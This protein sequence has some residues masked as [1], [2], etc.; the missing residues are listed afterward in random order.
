MQYN[1]YVF[2]AYT[3]SSNPP[4]KLLSISPIPILNEQLYTGILIMSTSILVIYINFTYI[5][6]GKWNVIK[7]RKLDYIVFPMS[8]FFEDDSDESIINLSFGH[9]DAY[10]KNKRKMKLFYKF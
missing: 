7:N 9:Q 5:Y 2:G 4:F 3:F 8:I 1:T 10:G 6:K